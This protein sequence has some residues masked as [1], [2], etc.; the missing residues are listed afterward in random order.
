MASKKHQSSRQ[1]SP[2]RNNKLHTNTSKSKADLHSGLAQ[3][4]PSLPNRK[5]HIFPNT[6]RRSRQH[7]NPR[8][9]LRQR[10]TSSIFQRRNQKPMHKSLQQ[11]TKLENRIRIT[12]SEIYG[13]NRPR[14][15]KKQHKQIHQLTK[16][17]RNPSRTTQTNST[18]SNNHRNPVQSTIRNRRNRHKQPIQKQKMDRRKTRQTRTQ[19]IHQTAHNMWNTHPR[20]NS[21]PNHRRNQTRQPTVRTTT[22]RRRHVQHKRNIGRRSLPVKKK[23]ANHRS[24]RSNTLPKTK[25]KHQNR[26]HKRRNNRMG[27]NDKNVETTPNDLRTTLPPQKQR[28]KHLWKLE[29]KMGRLQP[30]QTNHNTNERNTSQNHMPQRQSFNRSIIK[31]RRQT[32]LYGGRFI[33]S[34]E[35]EY[36]VITDVLWQLQNLLIQLLK[37]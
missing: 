6:K 4:L 8:Q 35:L 17:H 28:R 21:R 2:I 18:T 14:I 23:R 15:Q 37:G 20:N 34:E 36:K 24:N 30:M 32:S 33:L 27:K 3:L 7:G 1:V 11:P 5:N 16:N 13:N 26:K 12:H 19:N 22:K 9:L 25:Q 10:Q 29:T 31:P